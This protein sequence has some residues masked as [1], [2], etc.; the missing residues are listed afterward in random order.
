M[1]YCSGGDLRSYLKTAHR[2]NGK[3]IQSLTEDKIWYWF[4]QL[5]LGLHHMHQQRVLHRDV[6]AANIFL[7]NAGY[8]VLGDLGIAKTLTSGDMA[9]TVIGTPLY[10]APE[11]LDGKDYSFSS[12]VWALGCVLYELCT[13]KPPFKASH[14]AQLLNKICRTDYVP[15]QKGENL[16][17]TS[18]LPTLVSSMLSSRPDLRPSV[19]QLLCDSIARIHIRRY[20]VDRLHSTTITAEERGVLVQQVTAFGIDANVVSNVST[21]NNVKNEEVLMRTNV[22]SYSR[23][24]N[25]GGQNREDAERRLVAAREH[26]RQEHILFA[27]EKLQQ[28]RLQFPATFH[29]G[30]KIQPPVCVKE[31]GAKLPTPPAPPIDDDKATY[32]DPVV[33]DKWKDP[34]RATAKGVNQ[35]HSRPALL[36]RSHSVPKDVAFTGI[37]RPGVPLT[38]MAKTFAA[39]RPVCRDVRILKQQEA[40]KAAA[41]YRRRD[42]HAPTA[43]GGQQH[44]FIT[45]ATRHKKQHWSGA[46]CNSE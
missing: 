9:A 34:V 46:S 41:R 23:H 3:Q 15:I 17:S 6:K 35:T 19:D 36:G 14:P 24:K 21:L 37:P 12:D 43:G 2:A 33:S 29:F 28:L 39:R 18:R 7:S 20:C 42:V 45:C 44:D 32:T 8:L 22:E 1:E 40:A 27:L 11:V 13:G 26:D 10:M 31:D 30:S 38:G 5:A 4:V 25:Q 16:L